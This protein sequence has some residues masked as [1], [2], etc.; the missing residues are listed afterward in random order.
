MTTIPP[1]SS[2][3]HHNKPL[4]NFSLPFLN[5]GQKPITTSNRRNRFPTT[6]H[7]ADVTNPKKTHHKRHHHDHVTRK[8]TADVSKHKKTHHKT[9]S[10]DDDVIVRKKHDKKQ[11]DDDVIARTE[12]DKLVD[13]DVAAAVEV[14]LK[15][16]KLRP[17]KSVTNGNGEVNG[18]GEGAGERSSGRLLRTVEVVAA[19]AVAEEEDREAMMKRR[20]WIS[21]SKNEI[22]HDILMFTGAKPVRRPKKRNKIAQK[23]LDNVFPGLYLVGMS[24]DSY[25]V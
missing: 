23:N 16:W 11:T 15:P 8:T 3:T 6:S 2:R 20:L 18:N 14:E 10:D 25:R 12:S 17:R 22:E 4:H 13:V 7:P 5:W 19:E 1:P 21:L 9:T 24:A